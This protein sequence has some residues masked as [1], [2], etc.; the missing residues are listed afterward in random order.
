[1]KKAAP[2]ILLLVNLIAFG[3]KPTTSHEIGL[4]AGS[5][6]YLGEL[7]RTHFFPWNLAGGAFYRYNYDDRISITGAFHYLPIEGN[8][9]NFSASFEAIRN[10]RFTSKIYELSA[11]ASL[12]FL[13]FTH[14]EAK[15][16]KYTPYVYLGLGYFYHNP[17]GPIEKGDFHKLQTSIPMGLGIKYRTGKIIFGFD[18]GIRKTFTDYLD[19]LNPFFGNLPNTLT[20]GSTVDLED[21][22]KSTIYNK[23]WFVYSGIS[24]AVNITPKVVCRE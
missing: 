23:D 11:V 5:S 12:N 20:D 1:M 8:D 19:G 4:T 7:N 24:L 22:Q 6:Y 10:Q 17:E 15:S 13:N 14:L 21:F 18:W 9:E 2:Y 16:S 3:Q